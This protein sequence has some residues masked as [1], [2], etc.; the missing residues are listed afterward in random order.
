MIPAHSLPRNNE[1]AVLRDSF[2]RWQC[3]IRQMMMREDLGRP[4]DGITPELTL[5]G[6]DAPLG[7]IITVMNKTIANGMTEEFRHMVR[8][9]HDPAQRRENAIRLF[10]EAY[11]QK[12]DTF[13]DILTST[14]PPGSKGAAEIRAAERCTL[15]FEAFR[16]TFDVVCKVWVLTEHNPLHQSTYWHNMLFN[17]ALSES[18]VI[19]GFEPD[20]TKSTADPAPK[21]A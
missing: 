18:T 6:E 7:H 15:R 3:R 11:Y 9:T 10:S 8:K 12:A 4:S 20:W 21:G 14:F 16:Q 13:S 19:L 17:P 2:L 1:G 5:I